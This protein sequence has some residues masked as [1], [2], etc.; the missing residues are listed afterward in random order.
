LG[1]IEIG[2]M[3]GA[4]LLLVLG[5]LP[6]LRTFRPLF[7]GG[8]LLLLISA[9]I[10]RPGNALGRYLFESNSTGLH[11]PL[12]LFAVAWWVL[13]AWLVKSCLQLVLRRTVFPNDDRP[14]AKRLLADL[15]SGLVYVVA[16]VG[17]IETVLKEPISGVL[18]TSGVLA[19]V[20]GLALQNTLADVFSGIAINIEHPFGAGD[21][22]TLNGNVEGEVM[23]INWRA[24][25]LRAATNDTIVIPNSVIAKA[26]VTNHRHLSEPVLCM[27]A[28]TMAQ[29]VSPPK[30]IGLL[31]DAARGIPGIATHGSP[32][33]YACGYAGELV[34]YQL[35][36]G[37]DRFADTSGVQ[38][39]VICGIAGLLESAGLEAGVA[40]LKVRLFDSGAAAGTAQAAANRKISAAA[41]QAAERA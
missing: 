31:Q 36:F 9:L 15:A 33:A 38:S 19:I 41:A 18:A 28:I 20:L 29:D 24:T 34:S 3:L 17:I 37:V 1:W 4:G 32:S 6:S 35:Y 40:P 8:S 14:H 23:E 7:I 39:A 21:W 27:V 13:G 30:M 11:L 10:P 5:F 22:I 12:E 16:F 25:R 26:I 2:L